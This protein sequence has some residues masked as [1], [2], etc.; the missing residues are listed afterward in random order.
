M[1]TPEER[2]ARRDAA[3]WHVRLRENPENAELQLAFARWL[4]ASPRHGTAWTSVNNTMTIFRQA[5]EAW[6]TPAVAAPE[7]SRR[8]RLQPLR[9][10]KRKLVYT[11]IAATGAWVF[12]WPTVSLRLRA[13]HVTATG[14]ILHLRLADGSSV[15]LGPE[16]AL[17]FETGGGKRTT[18]LL[19]GQALF[20]VRR[21][22]SRPFSVEAGDVTTTV[23][24]TQFDVRRLGEATSVSV[25]RGHVRVRVAAP[26]HLAPTDLRAGEWI[27]IDAAGGERSGRNDAV[28]MG[29]WARGEAL[30]ENRTIA[31]VVE[32]VRPWFK[33]RIFLADAQLGERRI[34][35]IYAVRRPER[36]LAMMVR[37]YGGRIRRITPWILIVDGQ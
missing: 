34:T 14:E 11:A 19:A 15:E 26:S 12:L 20:D 29:G 1:T 25:A 17:A 2:T 37:P 31:D 6:R 10:Y 30:A 22:P 35:G 32:E 3:D 36:A 33:G 5:P 23:L 28:M 21:D 27:R 8:H 13:D 24:G 18:R 7:R 16:S 9:R 4:H